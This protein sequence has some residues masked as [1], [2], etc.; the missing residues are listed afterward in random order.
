MARH[1]IIYH[2]KASTPNKAISNFSRVYRRGLHTPKHTENCKKLKG[3]PWD[4][5]HEIFDVKFKLYGIIDASTVKRKKK[6]RVDFLGLT[7]LRN[8][9][10]ATYV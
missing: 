7:K 9:I 8:F 1:A 4:S 5:F 6:H 10:A 3:K 2:I